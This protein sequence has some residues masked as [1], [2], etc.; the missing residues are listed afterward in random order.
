MTAIFNCGFIRTNLL[1][2]NKTFHSSE[3][4]KKNDFFITQFKYITIDNKHFS[5]KSKEFIQYIRKS[6]GMEKIG[7]H[8]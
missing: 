8:T 3:L 4:A 1:K 6:T 7:M 2:G 5:R